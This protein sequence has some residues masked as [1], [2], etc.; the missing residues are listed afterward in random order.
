VA[1]CPAHPIAI[2]TQGAATSTLEPEINSPYQ[3][4]AADLR[5]AIVCGALRADDRLPTVVELIERYDVP[6]GTANRA[7]AELKSAGL[8]KASRGKRATVAEQKSP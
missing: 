2:D 7:V 8:I 6:A 5:G 1:G 3:K 4:I